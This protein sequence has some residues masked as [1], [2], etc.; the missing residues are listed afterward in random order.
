MIFEINADL[1]INKE[2]YTQ[3]IVNVNL[4]PYK[5]FKHFFFVSKRKRSTVKRTSHITHIEIPPYLYRVVNTR[6]PNTRNL[7]FQGDRFKVFL[8]KALCYW[9]DRYYIPTSITNCTVNI[10]IHITKFSNRKRDKSSFTAS[11]QVRW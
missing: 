10:N 3:E 6:I 5:N 7:N 1:K 11:V 8:L 4:I 9:N 2:L